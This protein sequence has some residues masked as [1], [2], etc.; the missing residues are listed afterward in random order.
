MVDEE[1]TKEQLV[2][3]LR[4]LRAKVDSLERYQIL[5]REVISPEAV[6]DSSDDD[7]TRHLPLKDILKNKERQSILN[8]IKV[9]NGNKT[10]AASMLRISY[11]WLVR[12]LN[13]YGITDR[14]TKHRS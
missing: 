2:D 7:G 5:K 12:R 6:R 3:E 1:K 4:Q 8:A 14:A 13:Y 10:K 11:S 9:A